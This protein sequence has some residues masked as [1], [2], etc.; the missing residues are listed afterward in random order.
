[1]QPLKDPSKINGVNLNNIR[2]EA[3]RHFRKSKREYVKVKINEFAM[4]SKNK[5]IRDLYM[6]INEFKKGYN[7]RVV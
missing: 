7:P 5:N 4:N 2:C 1:M 3:N 6:K